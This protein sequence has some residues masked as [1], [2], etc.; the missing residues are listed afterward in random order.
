MHKQHLIID[1]QFGSTGK[2]LYAGYLA[3]QIQ[4]DTIAYSPSPNAGHTLLWRGH[5][6][7]HKMLPSGITSPMLQKI[8]LGPGSLIDLDRLHAEL[9]GIFESLP[10]FRDIKIFVH[11][12]AACVYDRH[13]QAEAQ[14]GT[15]PGSTRQGVGAAQRER[16]LRSPAQ[17]NV[18]GNA[19]HPVLRLVHLVDTV[20]MQQIYGESQV[21]LVESCQGYSLSMY[22]G[23]YPYTTC[24][25]V[26]AASIM[27]DTGVPMGRVLPTVH[28]TFRTYP[29][30]V[31]NRPE[32]GEWSGPSYSDSAEITFESIGQQQELTTVTKLPR[33]L[34]TWSQRQAIE[35]CTQNR[36]SVGF[37]NFAQYP[38]KFSHLIDIW[39]QLN[40]CTQVK[41]LG[42]GPDIEDVYRVGSPSLEIHRITKIYERYRG[43]AT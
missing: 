34:F 13:R 33:R 22:H 5:S 14:G 32:S 17:N 39:E 3:R 25:D 15:A 8:V 4:C 29:I 12:H 20:T 28:G 18:I 36:I 23:Q 42:F 30:R 27:A 11:K 41:Y 35:A 31:A 1:A 7:I 38:I 10:R 16:I 2:G 9:C 40:E 21:L 43:A 24:R 26:T 37:L 6:F 19:D